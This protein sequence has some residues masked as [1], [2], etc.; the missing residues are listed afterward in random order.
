MTNTKI[1]APVNGKTPELTKDMS[2]RLAAL[3][4]FNFYYRNMLWNE[5]GA[6]ANKDPEFLHYLRVSSKRLRVALSTFRTY[7]KKREINYFKDEAKSLAPVLGKARDID[8]YLKFLNREV[9][10]SMSISARISLKNHI[11]SLRGH[12]KELQKE[13]VK[14]IKSSRHR[15]FKDR[16]QRFLEKGLASHHK[17]STSR[18]NRICRLEILE[19]IDSLIRSSRG[20]SRKSGDHRLHKFRIKCRKMRYKV[21]LFLPLLGE[22]G[23]K[24]DKMIVGMQ[25]ALGGQHDS[26]TASEKLEQFLKLNPQFKKSPAIRKLSKIQR[27]RSGKFRRKFFQ[28]L[29]GIKKIREFV[30]MPKAGRASP[31]VNVP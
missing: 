10:P 6:L 7:F 9:I 21:E 11:D 13:V 5:T 16:L 3:T 29:G 23:L 28:K 24:A 25:N 22:N 4:S 14:K 8:V 17:N 26:V 18:L 2:I 27:R 19:G 15:R 30:K 12:R 1:N 31:K 20:L